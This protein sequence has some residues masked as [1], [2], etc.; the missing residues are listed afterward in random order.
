MNM[1]RANTG[2]KTALFMFLIIFLTGNAFAGV[3]TEVVINKSVILNLNKPAA[4]VS[5]ANPAIADILLITPTEVQINGTA[6][7]ATSLLVW[8]KG[9]PK[10]SFFDIT[11]IGNVS[12]LDAQIKDL[13]PNDTITAQYANDSLVL[14][15]QAKN[16]QTKAKIEAIAK[17][18]NAKVINQIRIDEPQQVLLQVKVA[19]VD[20]TALKRLGISGFIKGKSAE[21][22]FNTIAAPSGGATTSTS[23]SGSGI[24]TSQVG[25]G[26]GI[27]GNVPGLGS[28]NPLDTFQAGISYF[29]GGIGSVIQALASKGLAKV[30][31]EPNMLVKSGQEGYFVAGSKI[32]IQIIQ[33]VG[34]TSTATITYQ[35]VGVKLRFKPEVMESGMIALKIDPAEVS[36][37]NGFLQTNGYPIIDTREVTTSVELKEGEGLVMAGLLSEQNIKNMSKIPILGDIPILGALFRSTSTDLETKE[38]VFFVTP[39]LVKA[40][41][42]GTKYE[43]PT[44]KPTPELD[45]E[46][47]WIPTAN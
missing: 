27:S 4:R 1:P 29:P 14:S 31:A 39:K 47:K 45:K 36:S 23:T 34:G 43:L 6:I 21:G 7:G 16:E 2:I 33:S 32:P 5:V 9:S 40:M 13:A 24:S 42:P 35:D 41:A 25:S 44:E 20:K 3:P 17:A 46:L 10:P 8:E 28:F 15:G 26:T 12:Q 37:V 38:L 30:L 22:F 11:V 19:Q 18:Y